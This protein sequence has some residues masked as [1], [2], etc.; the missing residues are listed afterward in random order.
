MKPD[1]V[2]TLSG[3][4]P[5]ERQHVERLPVIGLRAH[6][7]VQPRDSLHVVVEDVRTGIEHARHGVQVAAEIRRQHFHARFAAARAALRARSRRNGAS[8]RLPGRRG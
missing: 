4:A 5:R 7:A 2:S 3:V 8:R 6:A 1:L